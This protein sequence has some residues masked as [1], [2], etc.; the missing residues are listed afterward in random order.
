MSRGLTRELADKIISD[1]LKKLEVE[2]ASKIEEYRAYR[3]ILENFDD[4]GFRECHEIKRTSMD[5]LNMAT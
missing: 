2:D 4:L 5:V 3:D 1:H